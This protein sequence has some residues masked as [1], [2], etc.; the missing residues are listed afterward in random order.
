MQRPLYRVRPLVFT[1]RTGVAEVEPR[2]R[3]R[4]APEPGT[5]R[6]YQFV[7]VDRARCDAPGKRLNLSDGL[8]VTFTP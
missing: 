3:G 8:S 5:T 1:T 7:Y 6:H 4:R 2:L